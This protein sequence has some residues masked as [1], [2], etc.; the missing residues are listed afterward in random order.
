MKI[1]I[2]EIKIHHKNPKT[3]SE[4]SFQ[5]LIFAKNKKNLNKKKFLKEKSKMVNTHRSTPA[6]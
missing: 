1:H 2:A 5:N 6:S 3:F 4:N